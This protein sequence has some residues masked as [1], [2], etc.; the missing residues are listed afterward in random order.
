MRA[1]V[2]AA[3]EA[4]GQFEVITAGSGFEALKLLPRQRF[5]L[6][7]TD[8]N[9]PDINGLELIRF[10]RDSTAH[11]KVPLL[12]ISTDG[13]ER[14]RERGLKLGATDYLVKPFAPETLVEAARRIVQQP[15]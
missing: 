6:F 2:T 3:L 10:I 12:I 11:A 1:F 15:A 8:L 14:D 4:D 9:M 13:G 7:I 5:D